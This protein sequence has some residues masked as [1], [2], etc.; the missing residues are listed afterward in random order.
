L[1]ALNVVLSHIV[2]ASDMALYDGV[3]RESHGGW[4]VA[5][6]SWPLL[7][8]VAGANY[9][10]CVFLV[11]S[12]FVLAYA[13]GEGTLGMAALVVKRALRL[14]VPILAATLFAWAL[15]AGGLDFNH[16]VSQ[17][18]HSGWLDEQWA[19]GANFTAAL[20]EGIYGS[21]VG[22]WSF[23]TTYDSA[24]WTMQIEFAG[25]LVLIVLCRAGAW[26]RR[27]GMKRG[28]EGGVLLA[29][30]VAAYP[31]YLSLMLFGAAIYSFEAPRP[32]RW[33][34]PGW[35]GGVLLMLSLVLGTVPFSAAR[36]RVWDSIVSAAPGGLFT[37]WLPHRTGFI[38]MAPEARFHGAGAVLLLLLVLGWA[39]LRG[40][41]RRP[42]PQFLGR[43]SFPLYLMHVPLLLSVGCGTFLLAGSAGAGLAAAFVLAVLC[44]ITAAIGAAWACVYLIERPAIGL[45]ARGGGLVQAASGH[46]AG[47]LHGQTD[48]P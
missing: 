25:S 17:I 14:G 32:E 36:G 29:C 35:L 2:V 24:L 41:L 33:R 38:T 7:L 31:M 6:S 47:L 15:L 13:F 4:N 3:A 46:M 42:G 30:A 1:A 43:I 18:W 22:P 27:H 9:A 40:L 19:H 16:A 20:R 8:P 11:L 48:K 10:V 26:A 12:G 21:L 39:G 5:V 44:F 34:V 45:A 28:V 23:S 37:A